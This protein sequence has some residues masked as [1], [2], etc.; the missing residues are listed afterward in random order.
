MRDQKATKL[1]ASAQYWKARKL[2]RGQ[3]IGGA[4]QSFQSG[5]VDEDFDKIKAKLLQE[6]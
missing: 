1:S 3:D 4:Q 6:H 2:V 5:I